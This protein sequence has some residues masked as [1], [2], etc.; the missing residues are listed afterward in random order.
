MYFVQF[1]YLCIMYD[2]VDMCNLC[3]IILFNILIDLSYEGSH[4]RSPVVSECVF[5]NPFV[6]VVYCMSQQQ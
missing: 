3:M 6:V 1:V 5:I 2:V 4:L